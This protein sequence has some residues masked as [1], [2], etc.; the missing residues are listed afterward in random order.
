[1]LIGI[2]VAFSLGALSMVLL[3]ASIITRRFSPLYA[4]LGTMVLA[5]IS[6]AYAAYLI[7]DRTVDEVRALTAPRSGD[8]IYGSLFGPPEACVHVIDA[9]DQTIPKI[10]STIRL[11]VKTCPV[12]VRRVL[13]QYTYLLKVEAADMDASDRFSAGTFGDS[14]LTCNTAIGVGRNW[15]KLIISRDSTRMIVVDAAD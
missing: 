8:V 14:V 10:D 2:V 4:A 15:R 12:E 6:G 7:V 1:M 5:I 9:Q 13:Q 3:M 11:R